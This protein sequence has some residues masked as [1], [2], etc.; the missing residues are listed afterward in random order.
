MVIQEI[1]IPNEKV[2]LRQAKVDESS[3]KLRMKFK[4]SLKF[5]NVTNFIQNEIITF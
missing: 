3:K 4:P 1:N 2:L 5:D